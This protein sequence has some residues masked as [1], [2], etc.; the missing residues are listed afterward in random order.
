MFRADL[1]NSSSIFRRELSSPADSARGWLLRK[2]WHHL[3][4]D[5]NTKGNTFEEHLA[6][7]VH[8][9]EI[10]YLREKHRVGKPDPERLALYLRSWE[11]L[12]AEYE[13]FMA[14]KAAE[15][16]IGGLQGGE[17]AP[18]GEKEDTAESG[19]ASE[20]GKIGAPLSWADF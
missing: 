8:V 6:W 1:W 7:E 11:Q 5:I 4:T 10:G 15:T 14:K 18:A 13:K 16:E 19:K 20:T 2:L 17:A 9:H 12:R 3:P